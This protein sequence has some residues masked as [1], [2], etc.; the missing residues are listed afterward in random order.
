MD[1]GVTIV[2]G[3]VEETWTELLQDASP[4]T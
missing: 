2:K 3:E 4:E 1:E